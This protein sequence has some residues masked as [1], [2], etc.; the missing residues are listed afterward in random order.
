M[1]SELVKNSRRS[2]RELAKAIGTSQPTATRVRTKLEK[3]G[4]IKEYTAI[5]NL[6]KVGYTI[7]AL[8]FLKMDMEVSKTQ[9][10]LETFR[11]LHYDAITKDVHA[12]L[13]V[14]RGM[15]LGY[16]A[17]ILS[18][19]P[20]YS[21]CD[22]FRNILKESM[23]QNVTDLRTFLINLEEESSSLPLTF[24]LFATQLLNIK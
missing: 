6:S 9:E 17:V 16:D 12:V 2:D 19:H 18:L 21:A 13:L 1:L 11:K 24:S 8:N 3:E 7:M 15:G 22:Q 5:P 23:K 20:D 14:K 10:Q 4:Y